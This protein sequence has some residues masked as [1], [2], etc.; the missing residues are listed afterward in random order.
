MWDDNGQ[1]TST[2]GNAYGFCR[3]A[4]GNV[5]FLKRFLAFRPGSCNVVL[6]GW[7]RA[8]NI[9]DMMHMSQDQM[10]LEKTAQFLAVLGDS[11]KLRVLRLLQGQELCVCELVD[12]LRL[13]QYAVSRHLQALRAA[14][15]V[16]ARRSGR[17]MNYRLGGVVGKTHLAQRILELLHRELEGLPEVARDDARLAKRLRLRRSGQCVVGTIPTAQA[18]R[19]KRGS[20]GHADLG[21]TS[22]QRLSG[23]R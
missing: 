9:C 17:W 7:R 10:P 4:P 23:P 22:G 5:G 19:K 12:A 13:P 1:H 15:L 21:G 16:E 3:A 6:T 14:G 18:C 20:A 11:T 2:R 8:G